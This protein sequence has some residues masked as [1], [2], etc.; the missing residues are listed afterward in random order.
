MAIRDVGAI[1][2]MITPEHKGAGV[3]VQNLGGGLSNLM[4][5]AIATIVLRYYGSDGSIVDSTRS[6]ML[7]YAGFYSIAAVLTCFI[8]LHQPRGV[9]AKELLAH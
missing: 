2:P 3:S 5:P 7:I 8:R 9:R 6:I 1:F 4:G